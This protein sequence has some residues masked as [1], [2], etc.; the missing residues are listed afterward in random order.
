MYFNPFSER[1]SSMLIAGGSLHFDFSQDVNLIP[2]NAK[3]IQIPNL[4][5][6]N[7]Y[8]SMVVH[9]GAI[10]LCGGTKESHPKNG[11]LRCL[12]LEQGAWLEH[13]TLNRGRIYAS[14]VTTSKATFIFGGITNGTTY[15]YLPKG[16]D[17]WQLGINKIPDQFKQGF[18]IEVKIDQEIWL[19][20]GEGTGH[21]ILS[22]DIN[23]HTF[24]ELPMKLKESRLGHQCAF[25]PGSNKLIITGGYDY[26]RTYRK[27]NRR[28]RPFIASTEIIAI[29]DG[30]YIHTMSNPLNFARFGHGIGVITI[31]DED[32]LV[33]FGGVGIPN[34]LE[35]EVFDTQTKMWEVPDK[36]D[37][38][39]SG[40]GYL[41]V[42]NETIMSK[43]RSKF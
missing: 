34:V 38:R 31:D 10:L 20:G 17:T 2:R 12:Q 40:F 6:E 37:W 3:K 1:M 15:E 7:G 9:D 41:S 29:D 21:R 26:K 14:A 25:I 27:H 24:H 33:V 32:K 23:D 28:V 18:A 39:R 13:S 22:F 19:I 30:S 11:D 4:P 8:S 43:L 42:K 16:S 36:Q 35:M 5:Y